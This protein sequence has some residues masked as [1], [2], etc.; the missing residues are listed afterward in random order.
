MDRHAPHYFDERAI[1]DHER[2][3]LERLR[4]TAFLRTTLFWQLRVQARRGVL[5]KPSISLLATFAGRSLA[6]AGNP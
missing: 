2:I 5:F 6:D 1:G 4:R 3:K